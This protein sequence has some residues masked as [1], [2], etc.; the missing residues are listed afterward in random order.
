MPVAAA[1]PGAAPGRVLRVLLTFTVSILT[2]Y[3]ACGPTIIPYDGDIMLRVTQSLVNRHSFQIV[4]PI[5]HLNQP[6]SSYGPAVSVLLVPFYAAGRLLAGNGLFLVPLFEPL[7]TALTAAVVMLLLVELGIRWRRS[8]LVALAFAFGTLAWQ[9]ATRLFS[10]PVIALCLLSA[11]LCL[12]YYR[13]TTEARWLALAGCGLAITVTARIDSVLLLALPVA[14]YAALLVARTPLRSFRRGLHLLAMAAPMAAGLGLM[15]AYNWLRFGGPLQTGYAADLAMGFSTPFF[16][17]LY[18]LL[19]SPGAGLLVVAP[20]LVVAALGWRTFLAQQR[21]LTLLIAAL[22]ALRVLF[23]ASWWLWDG[24]ANLGPRLLVPLVPLLILPL[25][26][27][28]WSRWR[29]LLGL[30]LLAVSVGIEVLAQLVPYETYYN[31]VADRLWP[32]GA[33]HLCDGCG[34]LPIYRGIRAVKDVMDFSP[35]YSPLLGQTRLLLQG[36]MAPFWKSAAV[37]APLA[38][39]IVALLIWRTWRFAGL[40]D[41][42]PPHRERPSLD[43]VA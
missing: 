20:V 12:Q 7:L 13:R 17:G 29:T 2:A 42:G 35:A 27:V 41:E 22:L 32:A 6:Y 4:D 23:Y 8:L 19:L 10:E 11:V 33:T 36:Q 5:F 16:Q 26:W 28:S 30:P 25:A 3:L 18:G 15:L 9:Y 1:S 24:G 14:V 38:F 37:V 39:L 40:I 43:R 34:I 21:G 31:Q